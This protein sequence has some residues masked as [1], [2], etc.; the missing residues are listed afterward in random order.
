[1]PLIQKISED[2]KEA[3]KAHD[4]EMTS[5]LRFILA[6]LQGRQKEIAGRGS[7]VLKDDEA[8]KVLQ[9][10][11]KKR[12][13]AIALYE[14]GNRPE[15]SRKEKFELG[16]IQSYLPAELSSEQIGIIID[17]CMKAG[18]KE[19]PALMKAVMAR[20]AG[21]ADGKLVSELIKQKLG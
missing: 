21:Q 2:I 16:I 8:V 5:A 3:M 6:A 9:R 15:L 4:A 18:A 12:K 17:E 20:S 7:D 11:A 10:E 14:T 13:D 19:F 1:M